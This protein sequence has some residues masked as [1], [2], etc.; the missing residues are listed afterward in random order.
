VRLDQEHLLER[1]D[2]LGGLALLVEPEHGV[3]DGQPEDREPGREL[4]E[5]DD[6]DD[7]RAEQDVLHEVA[8]LAQ[9][10]VPARLLLGLGEL[11]R[12]VLREPLLNL[13]SVEPGGWLD[14]EM[15]GDVVSRR[16]VPGRAG[17]RA[18]CRFG[19]C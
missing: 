8:V 10:R 6:A 16:A 14:P 17:R 1:G 12:P 15:R 19:C 11:V 3:E 5:R 2:A 13:G 18:G 9:E 4:L 7:R